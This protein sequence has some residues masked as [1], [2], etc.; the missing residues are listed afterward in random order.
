MCG[1]VGIK[2]CD[3]LNE[4]IKM[5][6][7][8]EHRG[9]DEKQVTKGWGYDL[10]HARLSI[11]D[12]ANGSQPMVDDESGAMIV[13]NGEIYNYRQLR[14]ELGGDF[15]TDSDT[16][17]IL[18]LHASGVPPED[19]LQKLDGMFALAIADAHGLLLARDPLGI[20][21]L[22]VGKKDGKIVFGSEIKSIL[23]VTD[24]I[25]EFPPG[26]VFTTKHGPRP[27][28][29]IAALKPDT[30][31]ANEIANELLDR[32]VEAV[33]SRL[34]ADVPVGV[35]LSG[36]LDSSIISAVASRLSPNIKSFSVGMEDSEDLE[37]ARSVSDLLGTDHYERVFTLEEAVHIL[38]K[39]IYHLES[40]DVALVRSAVANWFLSELASKH[41]K[42]ALSGEGADELFAG[43]D[44]L[45]A[46]HGS[47]LSDE[48]RDI[49]D[50]LH[51]TNLQRCDRMSMAHGLEVRVPFL[52]DLKIVEYAL[53]IPVQFKLEPSKFI[54][55]WI[56]RKA[57]EDLLPSDIVWR[58]KMK[59]AYGTGIG[60][61][62][63]EWASKQIDEPTFKRLQTRHKAMNIRN[64]EEMVYFLIFQKQFPP[65][66]VAPLIG[67][68][69]SL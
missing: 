18:R 47:E 58:K 33:H 61:K 46:M 60:S 50:A 55:K 7:T 45:A 23:T 25:M 29:S 16:E 54:E 22:Y 4:I 3:N 64:I 39:V 48:L 49:T 11:I 21:P 27:Y 66:K 12:L 28:R 31:D 2:S 14:R 9:P 10:G 51:F 15:K 32:I 69:R 8:V 57:V 30:Y 63:S 13:F 36:G 52:D 26:Y 35:F 37:A 41:V 56:L 59:F 1:I 19:W 24:N 44:Y 40:F 62:L 6:T 53:A 42:V 43:Y 65:S 17:V 68:S 5:L 20:K 38:P 34:I 67:R